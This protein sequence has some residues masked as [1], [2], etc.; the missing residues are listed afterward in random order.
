LSAAI[1]SSG[2]LQSGDQSRQSFSRSWKSSHR[3]IASDSRRSWK[4]KVYQELRTW[5]GVAL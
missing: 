3:T 1:S 5:P 4:K 2:Q